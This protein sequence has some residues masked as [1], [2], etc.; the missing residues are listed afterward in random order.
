MEIITKAKVLAWTKQYKNSDRTNNGECVYTK[1]GATPNC[2]VA[3]FLAETA[4]NTWDWLL[5]NWTEHYISPGTLQ[6]V[7][8][9]LAR[10]AELLREAPIP[11]QL[12]SFTDAGAKLLNR[13]QSNADSSDM[14]EANT[15]WGQAIKESLKTT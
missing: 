12:V 3:N 10:F 5:A 7:N 13:I 1:D 6:P 14:G 11:P 9:N 15:A 2:I 4:P 8:Y